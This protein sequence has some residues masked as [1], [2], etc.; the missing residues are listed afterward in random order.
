MRA[1][2]TLL[3]L[4]V[5]ATLTLAVGEASDF[6]PA[7]GTPDS[8]LPYKSREDLSEAHAATF[9]SIVSRCAE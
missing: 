3:L 6:S 7:P 4:A 8:R 9:D 5:V 1:G 2:A